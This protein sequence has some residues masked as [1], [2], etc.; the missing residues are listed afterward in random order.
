MDNDTLI[1]L[2]RDLVDRLKGEGGRRRF[3]MKHLPS[4][5]LYVADRIESNPGS[6]SPVDIGKAYTTLNWQGQTAFT[7]QWHQ[8][9]TPDLHINHYD[10]SRRPGTCLPY[11]SFRANLPGLD[12]P[13]KA[14]SLAVTHWADLPEELAAV[15]VPSV[16]GWIVSREGV[17]PAA[18]A[19]EPEVLG[20]AQLA[21]QWPVA[22]LAHDTVMVVAALSGGPADGAACR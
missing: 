22:D 10:L 1:A 12:D 17:Q 2:P 18:L 7:G 15:G 6:I 14:V 19:V 20:L 11:D 8:V 9:S 16:A 5:K 3:F 4:E 13:G 21:Q